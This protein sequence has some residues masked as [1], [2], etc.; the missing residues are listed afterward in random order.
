MELTR[1]RAQVRRQQQLVQNTVGDPVMDKLNS[2][3]KNMFMQE[4]R[5]IPWLG[6]GLEL[7]HL[8]VRSY[9][10]APTTIRRGV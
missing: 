10:L 7:G 4:V 1:L 6:L 8:S 5:H 9:A 2:L 3:H